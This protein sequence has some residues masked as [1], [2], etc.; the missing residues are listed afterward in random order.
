M[1][2]SLLT[3]QIH[4]RFN[5]S[6]H[7]EI[8]FIQNCYSINN[9]QVIDFNFCIQSICFNEPCDDNSLARKVLKL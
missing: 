6:V 7:Y 1:A 8:L 2:N 5:E 4:F 3:N 9:N